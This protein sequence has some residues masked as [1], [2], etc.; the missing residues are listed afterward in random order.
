MSHRTDKADALLA[1]AEHHATQVV[2]AAALRRKLW[3]L[4]C[5]ALAY[6]AAVVLDPLA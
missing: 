3:H 1:T 2:K 6:G 4:V 5:A